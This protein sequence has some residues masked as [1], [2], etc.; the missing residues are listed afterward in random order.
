MKLSQLVL[1]LLL[2]LLATSCVYKGK[3]TGG[4]ATQ[5]PAAK[6]VL[7]ACLVRTDLGLGDGFFVRE[8][9]AA[10]TELAKAGRITYLS[11][12]EL[13]RE[14]VLEGGA[15]DIAMPD[16]YSK[17]PGS[18]TLEQARKLVAAAP[19]SDL[20]ILSTPLL[21]DSALKGITGGKPR[22]K[23]VL[24]LDNEGLTKL[25][26]TPSVP[27]Y[28][29]RYDIRPA[30]FLCGIAAAASS[31]TG[32]FI[33]MGTS[34]DPQVEDFL[35]AV[36]AGLKSFTNGAQVYSVVVRADAEG[37]ISADA[38]NRSRAAVL[39]AAGSYFACDH[40]VFSLGRATPTA[41]YAMTQKPVNGYVAGAYADYRIVRRAR[42][43]GCALKHPGA[44]LRYIFG[45]QALVQGAA[46]LKLIAPGGVVNVGLDQDAVGFT[47]FELYSRYNTDGDDL[48][49]AV[50]ENLAEIRSGEQQDYPFK[51]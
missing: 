12:G 45:Q 3:D 50:E 42:V 10:L 11:S 33:V 32:M 2:A 22:A 15:G 13:P 29:V 17:E 4:A 49:K 41:M 8:A 40:Y 20:L 5:T 14:R 30:A 6:P 38:F 48:K 23:A 9:D 35:T 46:G 44:A 51:D 27:V 25:P 24:I 28:Y 19:A 37:L 36:E 18:M 26:A 43:L 16:Q 7:S 31:N 21:L 1:A 34:A 47:T 39:K